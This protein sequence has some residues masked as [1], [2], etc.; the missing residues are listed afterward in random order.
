M[1]N[2]VSDLLGGASFVPHGFCLLWRPDL[3]AMHVGADAVIATSYLTIPVGIAVFVRRRHDLLYKKIFWLFAAFI[4][5]CGM[6]HIFDILTLWWPAYKA[7]GLVKFATALVS[8]A[9]AIQI[10]PIIP[11]A[12]AL[13]SPGLLRQAN[14][15]LEMRVRENERIN[16]QLAA[17]RDELEMR[18]DQR[19]QELAEVNRKL[20]EREEYYRSLYRATP[21]MMH[22]LDRNARVI[23][24]NDAWTARM[25]YSR[26]EAI[27]R[28]WS[29]FIPADQRENLADD[30]LP[31]FWRTGMA[32]RV[33]RKLITK[34][35]E[36]FET[37]ISAIVQSNGEEKNAFAVVVDVTEREAAAAELHR[38]ASELEVANE[39]LTHFTYVASHDLQEPLRKI[40]IFSDVLWQAVANDDRSDILGAASIMQSCSLRAR[41]VVADL[42]AFS[43]SANAELRI[44]QLALKDAV[45]VVVNDHSEAIAAAS[46]EIT[47]EIEGVTVQADRTQLQHLIGNLLA[48][49]LK[50]H[51]SGEPPRVTFAAHERAGEGVEFIVTDR[52]IGF[53]PAFAEIIFEPFKRL[54][55]NSEFPGSGIGLAICKTIAD[56]HRWSIRATS[57]LGKG[58][59]FSVFLP[60]RP[61]SVAR[62]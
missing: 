27:G 1:A 15:S 38:K 3:V 11:Q 32:D 46:A 9:T 20:A 40:V 44:E 62:A 19:T 60:D 8:A 37:E 12:L 35:G 16:A 43:R 61:R 53:E 52:G 10:W 21:V 58:S 54:H 51:R 56:R 50:Y 17:M 49:A 34:D 41:S 57:E 55:S 4:V 45:D 5:F 26:E 30:I 22:S 2:F 39:R 42:L 7:Q 13:P 14:E 23:E 59:R 31:S 47:F 48:N 25:G 28:S 18:V 33:R 36:T 6:S 29:D 24:V